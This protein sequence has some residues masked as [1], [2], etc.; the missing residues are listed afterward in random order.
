MNAKQPLANATR[1]LRVITHTDHTCAH[2]NLDI[3]E[4]G[5]IVQV[6]STVLKDFFCNKNWRR[7][8]TSVKLCDF[9]FYLPFVDVRYISNFQSSRLVLYVH[10]RW[11]IPSKPVRSRCPKFPGDTVLISV[12]DFY[13]VARSLV[14][15]DYLILLWHIFSCIL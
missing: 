15:K 8:T 13:N 12:I 7:K 10:E 4:M 5:G 11:R 1:G 3:S 14:L 2:A 9:E 6:P